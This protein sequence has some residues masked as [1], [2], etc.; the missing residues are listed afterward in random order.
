MPGEYTV[1]DFYG[2]GPFENYEDRQSAAMMGHYV[3]RVEDQY[4]YGYVRPQES[5]AHT[6]VKWMRILSE[7]GNGIE[8]SA[9]LP[10]SVNALP[11]ARKDMDL[12]LLKNGHSLNLK[13]LSH[14]ND[15]SS[16]GTYV[17]VDLKQMGL[18]CVNS[19]GALPRAEY[20]LPAGEYDFEFVIRPVLNR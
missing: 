10:F 12:S 18:G 11:F 1:L 9:E 13:A 2:K 17:N 19:W 4:H 8:L 15:R 20:M 3:Q 6:G 7:G 16:G 14:E 5:G